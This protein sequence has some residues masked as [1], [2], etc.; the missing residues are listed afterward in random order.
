M[1]PVLGRPPGSP[2]LGPQPGSKTLFLPTA[3]LQGLVLSR[4][5]LPARRWPCN[6][7]RVQG[8][9]PFF[10][11]RRETGRGGGLGLPRPGKMPVCDADRRGFPNHQESSKACLR[12]LSPV[13]QINCD[14]L[15]ASPPVRHL[16]YRRQQS[17]LRKEGRHLPF[18]P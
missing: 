10:R 12:W 8:K 9:A 15:T 4:L 3:N 11:C 5:R 6:G 17:S 7:C 13:I 14:P 1:R 2:V 18:Y 16:R